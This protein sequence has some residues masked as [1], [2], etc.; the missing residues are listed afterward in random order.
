MAVRA[1]VSAGFSVGK[2]LDALRVRPLREFPVPVRRPD[3]FLVFDLLLDNLE[4]R[5]GA[6]PRLE[7]RNPAAAAHLIVELPPQSFAEEAFVE[8][9]DAAD[10]EVPAKEVSKDPK[11][12]PKN[13]PSGTEKVPPLPS[14]RVR[15]AGRSRLAFTMPPG[16]TSL[17]YTLA[18]VLEAMRTWPP[19][20]SVNALPDPDPPLRRARPVRHRDWL[21]T[22]V[23]SSAWQATI[24]G[25]SS[26][27]EAR[28]VRGIDDA[29]A[30]GAQ[31]I[32]ER[33]AGGLTGSARGALG[34]VMFEALHGEMEELVRRFPALREDAAHQAA[35]AALSL[36]AAEALAPA[37]ARVG[38][39]VGLAAELPLFPLIFAPHEPP[40]HVTALEL[41]YRLILSP[42]EQARWRHRDAPFAQRGRTELWHTRLSTAA[43][44]V[45]P[46]AP[47]KVRALWSPDYPKG[48][49]L[50]P[51]LEPPLP[52][53]NSLDPLDRRMLVQLMAGY[54]EEIP[55]GPRAS[56]AKRLHL[57][58]LGGLLDVEGN[59]DRRPGDVDLQQW[60]HLATLGR[61]HYV[62]VVYAGYL[63]PYGHAAS[64]VKVTERKFES[65]DGDAKKR[66]AVLRQRFF[67]VCRER[68]KRYP[69]PG[70]QFGGRNFP[71]QQV[72][73]LTRVTPDLLPPGAPGSNSEVVPF[74][75][76]VI[77]GS[78]I[79]RRMVFWPVLS[80]AS[81]T[82]GV[83]FRFEILTTDIAGQ[84]ACFPLPLLFVGEV[85][86]ATKSFEVQRAYNYAPPERRQAGLGC[87]VC[88]APYDPAA[89]GDPRLPTAAMAFAA[90]RLTT[91]PRKELP[92]FHPETAAA[93]AGIPAL[94][95]MLGRDVVAGVTYPEVYKKDGFGGANAGELFLRLFGK[96][97][98]TYPKDGVAD[99][100]KVDLR[101]EGRAYPLE[102]GG[103]DGQAK[104]DALGALAAPQ[105]SILALSRIMGPVAGKE[106]P[107]PA[108]PPAVEDALEN[109]TEN[110]FEP[111]DFF[112]PGLPQSAKI[113]GGVDLG[114]ILASVAGLA[115]AG[116][117]KLLS[118]QLPAT[119]DL[120]ARLEASFE[121]EGEVEKIDKLK[122][123][124]PRADPL[125]APTK[126]VMKSQVTTPLA[127]PI[128][129]QAGASYETHAELNNF[130]VNLFGCIILWFERLHFSAKQGQKPDVAVELRQGSDAV[131]FGGPLE[132][133]NT[134][135]ELIPSN[136][137]SDPPSLA[138]TPSGITAGYSLNLP[139]IE[140]GIF[141]LSN[142]SLGAG[143]DLPF[144][145]RP[146]SVKFNFS[147]RQQPFSLTV[148]LLGGG[149]FFAIGVSARGVQEIE[150]A[151][152][153]GAALSIDLGVASGS[154]EIK[155]GVYFHWLEPAPN[156]GSVELAGYVRLHGELS[157]LGIISVSLTFELKLAYLKDRDAHRSLV[158]GEATLIVE[159]E[160]L[161]FS[162]DVSVR[163]R[164]DF[165][166]GESDPKFIAL[167]PDAAT[168][169][170][171][172]EAF[173]EEAA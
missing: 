64:L 157:V 80:S 130:K 104:S 55:D 168:W 106:P 20:L 65:L 150:A 82:K 24:A 147:E 138:V 56:A 88:Y 39:D 71:F 170:D 35:L 149:G 102:F 44:D 96:A 42:I 100:I 32:A 2:L 144:D 166:G 31:R 72:E 124:I 50:F 45:G 154:V 46:D 133:V 79:A 123:L 111:T 12:K 28:G 78:T 173:A 153:F 93:S 47:S 63:C 155:A 167:V 15:M 73:I 48:L 14:S 49:D 135:R 163:C 61:D 16:L 148:S 108:E 66:V 125:K 159:I 74:P 76:D 89:K 158:W 34:R 127:K 69:G 128:P 6:S 117:P 40:R 22:A 38:F 139:S 41:P 60:R 19:S 7:K 90:G 30:D 94:Q 33:A 162:M 97:Y 113:L 122:L 118:R 141:A 4:L 11:Y 83:D 54:D 59:W 21:G 68:I 134:L 140:V 172:C 137:F 3:D 77:Y 18:A 119:P 51:L 115:Q 142:A 164:R 161:F 75:G 58:A 13:V 143:F 9:S 37:A 5:P 114:E 85:A 67:I 156:K 29:L 107:A 99:A 17:P 36:A 160:I 57:S 171:Y 109:A 101:F 95:K 10:K 129:G 91:A 116:V 27:L 84:R 26:A 1:R 70:H 8:A 152:E 145:A 169:A 103:K 23:V 121:W 87:T 126:L 52:Y 165:A 92:S 98:A 62:R 86:N 136:G 25:L 131:Q 120:P 43:T 81:V 132:F 110:R 151:L 146:A 105:M 112:P 53:R